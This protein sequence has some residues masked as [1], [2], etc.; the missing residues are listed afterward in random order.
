VVTLCFHASFS[1]TSL[2]QMTPVN[3]I[4]VAVCPDRVPKANLHAARVV[5]A[6][7]QAAPRSRTGGRQAL[8]CWELLPSGQGGCRLRT[9][10]EHHIISQLHPSKGLEAPLS[11]CSSAM[12]SR[13]CALGN[14]S[15]TN[16]TPRTSPT[17]HTLRTTRRPI[18]GAPR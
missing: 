1:T 18:R 6:I 14:T 13:T 3:L 4:A 2:S 12:T 10:M 17:H 11:W 7:A 8:R 15:R 9:Y 16:R 5:S